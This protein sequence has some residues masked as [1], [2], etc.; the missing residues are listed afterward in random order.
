MPRIIFK[1]RYLK[2]ASEHLNNK[3]PVL[4]KK[5]VVS[6]YVLKYERFS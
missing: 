3:P 5:A 4:Y 1:C 2:N 6:I